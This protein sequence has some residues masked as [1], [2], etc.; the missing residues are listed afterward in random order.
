MING[1][2]QIDRTWFTQVTYNAV[3]LRPIMGFGRDAATIVTSHRHL[4]FAA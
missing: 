4:L 2:G 3:S 1:D